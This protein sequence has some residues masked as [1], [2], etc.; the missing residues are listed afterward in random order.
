[1]RSYKDAQA[2][3]ENQRLHGHR[4]WFNRCQKFVRF[5]VGAAAWGGSAR[6]AANKVPQSERH[7]NFPPPAGAIIFYGSSTK[8]NGHV[9]YASSKYGYVY[10]NDVRRKGAID[11]VP[12]NVFSSIWGMAPRF[13]TTWTPSGRAQLAP[14]PQLPAPVPHTAIPT[15]SLGR[16]QKASAKD[17]KASQGHKTYPNEVLIVERALQKAGFLS[18][19]YVDGSFGTLTVQAYAAWQ[20]HLG[21]SG[22]D[23]NG[24]P[25]VKS[26]TAL[27]Q[28]YGF[29]VS[30]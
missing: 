14:K 22:K 18:A 2:Y 13:W 9:A 10:S 8:G 26:L 3:A 1:M 6:I 21:Y 4:V 27:G 12:W 5:C 16:V 15:I 25:G 11:L 28:K 20:R 30:R 24:I 7:Y 23:A 29:K 19:K 17:P